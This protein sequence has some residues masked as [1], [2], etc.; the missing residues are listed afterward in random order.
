M[1]TW[2]RPVPRD[3]SQMPELASLQYGGDDSQDL[4]RRTVIRYQKSL[5]QTLCNCL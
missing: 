1:H 5:S 3:K 4:H 2:L